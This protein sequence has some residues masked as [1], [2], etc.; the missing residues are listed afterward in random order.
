M[1]PRKRPIVAKEFQEEEQITSKAEKYI[2]ELDNVPKI[3][4]KT[5]IPLV[6]NNFRAEEDTKINETVEPVYGL[7]VPKT[8]TIKKKEDVPLLVRNAIPGLELLKTDHEKYKHDIAHRPPSPEYNV[9]ISEF[10]AAL[11]RGMGWK[12]GKPV[13]KNGKGLIGLVDFKSRPSLLGLGAQEAPETENVKK[14]RVLPGDKIETKK[15]AENVYIPPPRK[16][17]QGV[18]DSDGVKGKAVKIIKGS[19][20]GK[21]GKVIDVSLRSSGTCYKI[22]T[23]KEVILAFN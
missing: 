4:P 10:G 5:V 22:D 12:E 21:T 13:G 2:T 15:S 8:Q 14:R 19:H 7:N 1:I 20:A 18:V 16:E 9:P 17:V 6:E 23:K 11:M 3:K